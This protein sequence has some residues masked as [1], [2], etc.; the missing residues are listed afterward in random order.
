[1]EKSVL[2]R[3]FS[4]LEI[5]FNYKYL[6]GD[7]IKESEMSYFKKMNTAPKRVSKSITFLY[8]SSLIFATNFN[9]AQKPISMA[10]NKNKSICKEDSVMFFQ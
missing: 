2:F 1:M 10:G 6:G 3:Q 5:V 9:P 8:P 7:G 4:L